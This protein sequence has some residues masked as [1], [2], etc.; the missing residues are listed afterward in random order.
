MMKKI[1]CFV[2]TVVLLLVIPR[3]RVEAS[4]QPFTFITPLAAHS[5]SITTPVTI[6]TTGASSY[7]VIS[8][9]METSTAVLAS[10]AILSINFTN[11][12]VARSI[13]CPTLSLGT[14]TPAMN[15]Y[16]TLH[17]D[18]GTAVTYSIV[19]V[20]TGSYNLHIGWKQQGS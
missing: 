3:R 2:L 13:L 1:A 10:T 6:F 14:L 20:S 16:I 11:G 9:Y 18:A 8:V 4:Y 19:A 17:A 12:G 15:D 5:G 7:Y